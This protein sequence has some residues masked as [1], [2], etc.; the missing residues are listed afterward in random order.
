MIDQP[1]LL[2]SFARLLDKSH[3]RIGIFGSEQAVFLAF[4]L[5]VI[6]EELLDLFD[7]LLRQIFE[8]IHIRVLMVGFRDRDEPIVA[9][10]LFAFHLLTL[11]HPDQTR[12]HGDAGEGWLIH[13]QENVDRIA[14]VSFGARQEAE[15]VRE[16]HARRQNFLHHEDALF[17]I[18]SEL[19]ARTGRC[20]NDDLDES[21]FFIN[22]FKA[23]GVRERFHGHSA[24][25]DAVNIAA[26]TM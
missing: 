20:L 14:I 26:H 19:V 17:G 24:E 5:V 21:G 23:R 16:S 3:R 12:T 1:W 15:I 8:L 2:C 13:E 25:R 7:P 4:Q 18:V 22:R 6:D 11:N 10:L 9:G